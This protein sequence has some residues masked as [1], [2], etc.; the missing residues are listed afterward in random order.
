MSAAHS[1]PHLGSLPPSMGLSTCPVKTGMPYLNSPTAQPLT[2]TPKRIINSEQT[3]AHLAAAR[4]ANPNRER[5]DQLREQISQL[6][7]EISR[8]TS[9]NEKYLNILLYLSG[10]FDNRVAAAKVMS[11]VEIAA[12]MAELFFPHCKADIDEAILMEALER[13]G[14]QPEEGSL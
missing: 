10:G 3:E 11:D 1:V 13:L 5:I 8:L 14:W 12:H 4:A 9:D 7:T 2:K 6:S